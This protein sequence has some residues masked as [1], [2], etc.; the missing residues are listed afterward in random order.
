[1]TIERAEMSQPE[2]LTLRLL[3]ELRDQVARLD[4]KFDEFRSHTDDRFDELTRL[5]AGESVMARYAAAGVD[6]RLESL[7]SRVKTLEESH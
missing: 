4:K 2:D 1:L 6:S 7:E 5:F 3:R